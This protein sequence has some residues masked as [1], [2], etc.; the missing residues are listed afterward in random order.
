M[1]GSAETP[2]GR[3]LSQL[4]GSPH[5]AAA[6]GFAR[7]EAIGLPEGEARAAKRSQ[8]AERGPPASVTPAGLGS[9]VSCPRAHAHLAGCGHMRG[10]PLIAIGEKASMRRKITV[11]TAN[12]GSNQGKSYWSNGFSRGTSIPTMSVMLRVTSVIP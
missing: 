12:Y 1:R 6:T 8:E 3:R 4:G 5:P 11:R 2:P 7:R 10:T 9:Q